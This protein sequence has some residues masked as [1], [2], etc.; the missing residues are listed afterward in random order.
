MMFKAFL[1]EHVH[2]LP[3]GK[4]SNV[5]SIDKLLS[6]ALYFFSM[7]AKEGID[8]TR[9]QTYANNMTNAKWTN[10]E[11]LDFQRGQLDLSKAYSAF[12][13]LLKEHKVV[14][15]NNVVLDAML[16]LEREPFALKQLLDDYDKMIVD[17]AHTLT[18]AAARIIK[19][20]IKSSS[21]PSTVLF[22]NLN[23]APPIPDRYDL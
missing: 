4:F 3:L 9:Y 19:A 1:A 10:D 2:A 15:S 5:N 11:F 20:I 22:Q 16:Y 13:L 23:C 14:D 8:E 7:L 21:V 6:D 17:D 12:R 18:P